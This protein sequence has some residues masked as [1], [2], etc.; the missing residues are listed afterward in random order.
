LFCN[1]ILWIDTPNANAIPPQLSPSLTVYASGVGLG[2]G[3][4]VGV[5]VAGVGV[6]VEVVVRVI[7]AVDVTPAASLG[8]FRRRK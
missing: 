1:T 3:V 8:L 2:S 4:Y 5:G 7:V 6:I